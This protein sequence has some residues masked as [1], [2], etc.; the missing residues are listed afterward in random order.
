[1][2]HTAWTFQ[3]LGFVDD[4][5]LIADTLTKLQTAYRNI[6]RHLSAWGLT[7]STAKTEAL[8]TLTQRSGPLCSAT[9]DSQP[10]LFTSKLKYLGSHMDSFLTCEPD[11]LYRLDQARKGLLETCDF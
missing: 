3:E 6:S 2:L 1:M 11:I 7:V 9:A 10:V 4:L 5:A 8:V